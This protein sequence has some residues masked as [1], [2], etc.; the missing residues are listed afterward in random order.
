M[1]LKVAPQKIYEL[2]L[3]DVGKFLDYC[4][5][6]SC[7]IFS[8][9]QDHDVSK[10]IHIEN[11]NPLYASCGSCGEFLLPLARRFCLLRVPLEA[12][13]RT[14]I[15]MIPKWQFDETTD[16]LDSNTLEKSLFPF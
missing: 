7:V 9:H 12:E 1:L 14:I 15:P 3:G 6:V 4:E 13:E 11:T 10:F 2:L 5:I 16:K 8:L